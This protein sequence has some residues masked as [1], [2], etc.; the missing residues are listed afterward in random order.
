MLYEEQYLTVTHLKGFLSILYTEMPGEHLPHVFGK[1]KYK[2]QRI[3][4]NQVGTHNYELQ[5]F[6][7][8]L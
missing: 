2:L 8:L 7:C 3:C 6:F 1:T 4:E 5:G